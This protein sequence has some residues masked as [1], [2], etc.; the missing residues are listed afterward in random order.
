MRFK[1]AGEIQEAL[2]GIAETKNGNVVVLDAGKL[3]GE[4]WDRLV[5]N[6]VFHETPEVKGHARWWIKAAAQTFGTR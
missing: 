6:A 3:R 2:K 5:F 1:N 4:I